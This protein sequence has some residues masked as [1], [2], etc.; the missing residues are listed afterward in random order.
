MYNLSDHQL[1]EVKV[2]PDM[3]LHYNLLSSEYHQA[4]EIET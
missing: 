1:I 3:D 2:V 4:L